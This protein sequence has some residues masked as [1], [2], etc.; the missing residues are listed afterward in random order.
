M[1]KNNIIPEA[2]LVNT[3]NPS[4]QLITSYF[5]N[6]GTINS[7]ANISGVISRNTGMTFFKDTSSSVIYRRYLNYI[8]YNSTNT[9]QI[10]CSTNTKYTSDIM[11]STNQIFVD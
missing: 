9:V 6:T 2:V 7:S 3:V 1:G 11:S 8:P 4:S 10:D 5:S